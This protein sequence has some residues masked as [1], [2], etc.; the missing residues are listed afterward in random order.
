[1][2]YLESRKNKDKG[3]GS[4]RSFDYVWRKERAKLRSG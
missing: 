2:G 3:K 1:M 4:R